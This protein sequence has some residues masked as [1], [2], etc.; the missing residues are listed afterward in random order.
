MFEHLIT[1]AIYDD[2][3]D[4]THVI[5]ATPQ[6]L[7]DSQIKTADFLESIGATS[8]EEIEVKAQQKNAQLAFAAMAAG[9]PTE[10]V[11]QTLL[12]NT[13]PAAVKHLV[14][15]L[16]AYDWAFVEQARQMRGYAVAKILEDTEHPDP[17][18]RLKALEML[19]RV[20]EVALFTERVEVKKTEMSDEEIES[21][22]KAKLGKYMG[23]IE[24]E[25]SEKTNESK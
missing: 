17:R 25:A 19:G 3:P 15:M 1:P 11:K 6:E 14:G 2:T 7:L 4:I 21:K 24:V 10:K 18:Y 16:T 5:K 12:A 9:A 22:I 20:T 8:D 13:T 23:A